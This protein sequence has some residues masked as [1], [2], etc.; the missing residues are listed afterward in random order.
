MA[1]TE[2]LQVILNAKDLLTEK[3][4]QVNNAIRETGTTSSTASNVATAG[5]SR[6]ANAY[7]SASN[8]IRS[9]WQGVTNTIRNSSVGQAVSQSAIA[10]PFLNAAEKIRNRWQN[11]K[12][13]LKSRLNIGVNGSEANSTMD[14]VNSKVTQLKQNMNSMGS[15]N[16][17]PAG[18]MTLNGQV[19]NANTRTSQFIMTLNRINPALAT[20][21][22]KGASTFSNLAS[23]I[24][25]A[26]DRISNFASGMSGLQGAISGAFGAVGVTSVKAFTIEAAMA[27]EKVNAVTRSVAGSEQAFTKVQSSIKTAVAGTTLGYNNMAKAVNTVGLRYHMTGQQLEKIPGAMSKVGLMAQAMGKSN[28]EAAKLMESAYDGLQ[29]KWKTLKTMGITE[30]DLKAA[31]WSGAASD[32]DG[33]TAALEKVLE[34]NPKLKE[35]TNTTEYQFA[36]LKM[37]IQGVG[38]EI[39]MM[40]LPVIKSLV[41]TFN[42]LAKNHPMILKI[43][44][45]VGLLVMSLASIS[46]IVLPIMQL[47]QAFSGLQKVIG[48]TQIKTALLTVWQGIQTAATY[49]A[50]AAQWLWN[51]ALNA[52]PIGIVILAIAAFVAIL[53]YLY[54]TNEDV[55]NAINGLWEFLKGSFIVIWDTLKSTLMGLWSWLSGTFLA[56]WDW[57]VQTF[58]STGDSLQGLGEWLNWLYQK[59]LEV[60]PLI[61]AVL[62]P[63]TILFND[64]LRNGAIAAV[65]EFIGW[66]STIGLQIWTW[67]MNAINYVII[68]AQTFIMTMA[69]VAWNAVTSFISY[70][71]SLPVQLWMWLYNAILKAL[72]FGQQF[73]QNLYNAAVN[74]VNNFINFLKT[75]PAKAWTVFTSV[76]SKVISFASDFINKLR[77]CAQNAVNKF[78]DKLDLVKVVKDELANIANKIRNGAGAIY[79]AVLNLARNMIS[80][81]WEGLQ[82]GSPGKMAH[83]VEDEM[84]Y[85]RNYIEEAYKPIGRSIEGL[86]THITDRFGEDVLADS[87]NATVTGASTLTRSIEDEVSLDIR[88]K[89]DEE[90]NG[91]LEELRDALNTIQTLLIDEGTGGNAVVINNMEN[92]SSDDLLSFLQEHITDNNILKSIANS[93]EFQS[94]DAR[95]KRRDQSSRYRHI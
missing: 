92:A 88:N 51:V 27:R 76:I 10:Q 94:F 41:S 75:L 73:R 40:I 21:G 1:T 57:L 82:M 5:T 68:W 24:G 67:L 78:K 84:G 15:F 28:E 36:S 9:I 50:T 60:L 4:R 43:V 59:F 77:E 61:M 71:A 22:A 70:I 7:Q 74:A 80:K 79:D 26:K 47:M 58:T 86:A 6:I 20:I 90:R 48:L 91:L 11:L 56:V 93:A 89:S 12:Q 64:N 63:W 35:M 53:L 38:T 17:S 66:I 14:S 3:V 46:M 13:T 42:D 29:G 54:N 52:N 34:K 30:A 31:G 55:R 25:G 16:I 44:V 65:Q 8:R 49:V 33:Y 87:L 18:L 85:I 83:T 81:L 19:S 62:A 45:A 2:T 37:S 95:M 23:K 39:G 72:Q 69:Q 32:V